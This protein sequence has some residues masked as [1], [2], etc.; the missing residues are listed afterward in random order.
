MHLRSIG[1]DVYLSSKRCKVLI[2]SRQIISRNKNIP[3][4]VEL[5]PKLLAKWKDQLDSIF[6]IRRIFNAVSIKSAAAGFVMYR[7]T[8]EDERVSNKILLLCYFVE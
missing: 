1:A 7:N 2:S 3:V 6:L 5:K 4:I 8:C